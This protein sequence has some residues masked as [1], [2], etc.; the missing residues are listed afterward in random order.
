MGDDAAKGT[1]TQRD[2]RQQR[3]AAALRQNLK[4][5]KMQARS[6]K[7]EKPDG[8]PN[9]EPGAAADKDPEAGGN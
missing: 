8:K 5:R 2:K 9:G 4:R 6:R 3:L 1:G 7:D